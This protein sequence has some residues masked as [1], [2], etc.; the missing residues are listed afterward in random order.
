MKM[1]SHIPGSRADL[2]SLAVALLDQ[3]L[4]CWGRDITRP[5]GNLL[6]QLGMSRHRPPEPGRG[7]SA[8]TGRVAGD[9]V[10]WLWGFGIVYC[11]P[12]LGGVFLRRYS[13]EPVLVAELRQPVH[14]PEQV[15]PMVRPKTARQRAVACQ[16]VRALAEWIAG[17]EHWV[18]ETLGVAYRE[19]TL[20]ARDRSAAVP[21]RHMA[22]TW[23]QV[24]RKSPRLF[25]S[26]RWPLDPWGKL[27]G[28]LHKSI[29]AGPESVSLKR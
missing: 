1:P 23:V 11:L 20:A 15:V 6:L 7:G 28:S 24:G 9:G 2:R 29:M 10:I 4:W 17:Y 25:D 26:G 5:A 18:A 12:G 13:F 27:L 22:R 19:E 3:Q 16:L 14:A 8:Y 21:A